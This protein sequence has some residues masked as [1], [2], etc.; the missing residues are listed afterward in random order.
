MTRYTSATDADREAMLGAIG[1][2]AVDDLFAEIPA[3][4]RL[5]RALDLPAGLSETECFDHLA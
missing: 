2:G 4:L 1:V 5:G 3:D